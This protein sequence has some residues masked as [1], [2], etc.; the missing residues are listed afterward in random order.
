MEN[1]LREKN[2]LLFFFTKAT[3]KIKKLADENKLK[4]FEKLSVCD[5]RLLKAAENEYW[6]HGQF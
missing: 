2:N 5:N 4:F 3:L 6:A 1:A